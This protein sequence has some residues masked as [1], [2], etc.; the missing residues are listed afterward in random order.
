M[1]LLITGATGY[2]GSNLIVSL[3]KSRE[4]DVSV[5]DIPGADRSRLDQ[6]ADAIDFY[7][8]GLN[9]SQIDDVIRQAQPDVVIHLAAA[10]VVSHRPEEIAGILDANILFGTLL[11]DAMAKNGASALVNTGSFWEE[12][13]STGQYRPLNLYAA[14]KRAYQD[15]LKYYQDAHGFRVV[16]LR[17]QGVYGPHDPRTKVFSLFRKSL[18]VEKPIPVSPGDQIMDMT[19]IE[20]VV[21]AFVK[22][23][24]Y[25]GNNEA[26]KS[27]EISI[28][29]G[30]AFSLREIAK[31]YEQVACRALNINWGGCPYRDREVMRSIADIESAARILGWQ[32]QYTLTEGIR[33]MLE[34]EGFVL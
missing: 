34:E 16:T 14:T 28:G 23:A 9:A 2:I 25:L 3:V 13:D 1:K 24:G 21:S 30:E 19:Y 4:H 10:I 15:I 6:V 29:S 17:L 22:A 7:E 31:L 11:A 26:A 33:R 27:V 18:D 20:D 12:M 5:C 32:P 8:V